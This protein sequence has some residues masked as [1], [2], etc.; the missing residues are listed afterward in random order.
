MAKLYKPLQ[1]IFEA[2]PPRYDFINRLFTFGMDRRWRNRAVKECLSPQ[3]TNVLDLCCG[4]GDLAI[5]LTKMT[6][7]KTSII[8]LD[9]SSSMLEIAFRKTQ[10]NKSINGPDFIQG[11]AAQLPFQ[12]SSINC[13]GISFAFRNLTYKNLLAKPHLEE[14]LRVLSVGGKYVIVES[15]QPKIKFIKWFCHLYLRYI[16]SWLGYL[17][18]GNLGAY[19]YLSESAINF[20]TSDDVR[21]M[22]LSAGFTKVNYY[23]L[24]FGAAGIHVSYK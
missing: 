8:G 5:G 7:S 6:K 20:H 15:S 22:L 14:V 13:V 3:V 9:Y 17:I 2:I 24:F 1:H 4:T 19:R 21:T 12:D 18:S 11:N 23:P 10:N 16:V